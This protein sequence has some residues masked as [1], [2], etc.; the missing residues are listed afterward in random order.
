MKNL[1]EGKVV[2]IINPTENS[3]S[4]GKRSMPPSGTDT[5]RRA[6]AELV[7]GLRSGSQGSLRRLMDALWEPLVGYAHRTLAGS[8]DA[9]G[10]VQTAFVRLWERRSALSEEGSLKAL[11]YT[12][13]R[14]ACLDELRKDQR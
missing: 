7:R 5:T 6:D 8:G 10:M 2:G 3:F 14:N 9:E 4:G 1:D 13:V 11:L 12:I